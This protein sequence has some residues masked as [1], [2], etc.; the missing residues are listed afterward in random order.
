MLGM[1]WHILSQVILLL[2]NKKWSTK[3]LCPQ[4]KL[5]TYGGSELFLKQKATPVL[6]RIAHLRDGV[7]L[8]RQCSGFSVLFLGPSEGLAV[9]A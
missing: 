5:L 8:Y 2:G 7:S 3:P 1:L 4:L 6:K 9:G